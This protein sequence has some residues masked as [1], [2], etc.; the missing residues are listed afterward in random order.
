MN[1]L[2]CMF[3]KNIKKQE[4]FNDNSIKF[5]H[6]NELISH[7][8]EDLIRNIFYSDNVPKIILV[9]DQYKKLWI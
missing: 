8:S 1:E 9:K 7:N 2:I 6:E 4:L 3:F 5:Y